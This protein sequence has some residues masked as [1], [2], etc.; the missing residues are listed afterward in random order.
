MGL[1]PIKTKSLTQITKESILK[2]IRTLNLDVNNKLPS[3]ENLSKDLGV[4]RITV[5]SALNELATEGVIFR[6]QGKGTYINIEAIKL[7]TKLN[8]I[9]EFGEIIRNSGYKSKIQ[10]IS[11]EFIN[12]DLS[13]SNI[14]RIEEGSDVLILKKTFFADNNACVYCIDYLPLSILGYDNDFVSDLLKYND[15][16][17]KFLLDKNNIKISWDKVT[18][19]TTNN[20]KE[21]ELTEIFNCKDDIKSFLILKGVNYDDNDTPIY[22]T[23]EYIDT[24]IISFNLIRQRVY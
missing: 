15:S 4:S 23:Y 17:Y 22:L 7:N 8:P 2:Y 16:L 24:K 3:E 1:E 6:R 13:L 18:I 19:S 14:L 5:R 9:N 11:H 12:A 10:N 20:S 21:K